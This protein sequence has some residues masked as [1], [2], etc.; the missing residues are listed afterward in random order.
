M[1]VTT[2]RGVTPISH[3]INSTQPGEGPGGKSEI[4]IKYTPAE[5]LSG[6]EQIRRLEKAIRIVGRA[7]DVLYGDGTNPYPDE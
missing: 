1:V 3:V 7:N 4:S 6:N 2:N 5:N